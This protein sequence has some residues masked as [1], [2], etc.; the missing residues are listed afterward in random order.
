[1]LG[2][3]VVVPKKEEIRQR[4]RHSAAPPT[5]T[6]TLRQAQGRLWAL[7]RTGKESA[8]STLS[9]RRFG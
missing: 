3:G 9:R 5:P 2:C 1:M 8:Q 7:P 4:P 6:S